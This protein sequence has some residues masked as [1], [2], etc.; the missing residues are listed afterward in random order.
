VSCH[1]ECVVILHRH[2]LSYH[3]ECVVILQK[4]V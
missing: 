3:S 2:L 1:S 4:H